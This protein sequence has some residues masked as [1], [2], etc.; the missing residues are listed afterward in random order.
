M[1]SR[2]NWSW[3][4][5]LS[6]RRTRDRTRRSPGSVVGRIGGPAPPHPTSPIES[7]I[8]VFDNPFISWS[9]TVAL[10][11]SGGYH[12]LQAVR[13][14][15]IAERVN[16]GLHGVMDLVMAAMLWNVASSTMLAQIAVLLGAAVWFFIQ[17]I[18]RPE[19]KAL[20]TSRHDRMRCIYH[21]LL[22]AGAAVMVAMMGH[23]FGAAAGAVEAAEMHMSSS[24]HSMGAPA[25]G[26]STAAASLS[27]PGMAIGLTAFF[28]A[29]AAAFIVLLIRRRRASV[30]KGLTRL[31]HGLEALGAAIMAIMSF[32]MAA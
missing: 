19:I 7:V 1:N 17:A 30:P 18:A 27:S 2:W 15:R 11:V 5:N 29:A 31:E 13:S 8:S 12:F 16:K 6:G 28:A 10:L 3:S 14:R 22:M 26:T 24:H 20:C 32:S 9:L 23:G 25:T 4:A 21:S